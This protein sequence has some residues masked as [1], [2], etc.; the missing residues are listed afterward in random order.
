MINHEI[1]KENDR[2]SG[3]VRAAAFLAGAACAQSAM[4]KMFAM[5]AAQGGI[6][7]V[8]TSQL[9][10][11]EDAQQAGAGCRAAHGQRAYGGQ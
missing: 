3:R 8:M 9:A 11:Q 6:A 5:K 10:L 4:D 1:E 7:E 2:G